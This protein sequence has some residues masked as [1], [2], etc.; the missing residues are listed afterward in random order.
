MSEKH[1]VEN[2]ACPENVRDWFYVVESHGML[3]EHEALLQ[4]SK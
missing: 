4:N 3:Q 2:A 1:V